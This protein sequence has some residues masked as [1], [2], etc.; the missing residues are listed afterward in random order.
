MKFNWKNITIFAVAILLFSKTG[1]A[2]D[3]I[4]S[5][6]AKLNKQYIKSYFLDGKDMLISPFRWKTKDWA[7]AGSTVGIAGLLYTQ[8]LKIQQ[9]VQD[10]RTPYSDSLSKYGLEPWGSGFYS[11]PLFGA[12]YLQGILFKNERS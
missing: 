3:S 6:K 9:Y 7:I 8:D 12:F 1:I 11:I 4:Y 5:D 2:Q 10:N